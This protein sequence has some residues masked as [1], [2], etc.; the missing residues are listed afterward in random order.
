MTNGQVDS[1]DVKEDLK[2]DVKGEW[3]SERL[4]RADDQVRAFLSEHPIFSLACA[5]GIGYLA[6]RLLRPKP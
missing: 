5:V 3:V 1:K 4:A 6:A 2:E